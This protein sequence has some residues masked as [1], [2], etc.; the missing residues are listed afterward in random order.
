MKYCDVIRLLLLLLPQLYDAEDLKPLGQ[1]ALTSPPDA[2]SSGVARLATDDTADAAAVRQ[3]M[4]Q[5][6]EKLW[7]RRAKL[8]GLRHRQKQTETDIKQ[9]NRQSAERKKKTEEDKGT[10]HHRRIKEPVKQHVSV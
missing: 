10:Q 6:R 1:V 8:F 7:Q 4:A 3:E 2:L 9:D 5:R